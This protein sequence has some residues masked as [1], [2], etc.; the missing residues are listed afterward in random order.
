MKKRPQAPDLTA[1]TMEDAQVDLW[2]WMPLEPSGLAV[3]PP[4]GWWVWV[5]PDRPRHMSFHQ[6]RAVES[7]DEDDGRVDVVGTVCRRVWSL[8]SLAATAPDHHFVLTWSA[9]GSHAACQACVV[10][11]SGRG[12]YWSRRLSEQRRSRA[13]RDARRSGRSRPLRGSARAERPAG[14]GGEYGETSGLTP[15]AVSRIAAAA[16]PPPRSE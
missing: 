4:M 3:A 5:I 14:S 13:A 1:V 8:S 9:D 7:I 6:V 12:S 10:G 16:V 2:P 15:T 11:Y